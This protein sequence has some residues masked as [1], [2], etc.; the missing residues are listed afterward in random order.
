MLSKHRTLSV[1]LLLVASSTLFGMEPTDNPA[2]ES[3][4]NSIGKTPL[5]IV[6]VV[7]A[8]VGTIGAIWGLCR[9]RHH[10]IPDSITQALK[11]RINGICT[12]D[13]ANRLWEETHQ[14]YNQTQ[15]PAAKASAVRV[16]EALYN[17]CRN[18][19]GLKTENDLAT[20]QTHLESFKQTLGLNG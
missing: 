19:A 18:S 17:H 15:D 9:W 11:D 8:G 2:T 6:G 10:A 1:C 12:A 7:A 5:I 16:F 14:A 13:D 4:G 20:W 3:D